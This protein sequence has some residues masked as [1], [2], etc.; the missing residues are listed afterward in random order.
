VCLEVFI[1]STK[2]RKENYLASN[3]L[4]KIKRVTLER[5]VTQF[6]KTVYDVLRD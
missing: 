3:F 6:I 2:L 4:R 5:I 1:L